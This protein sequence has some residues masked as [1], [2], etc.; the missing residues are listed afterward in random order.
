M[1]KESYP[2][3]PR[4]PKI[5]QGLLFVLTPIWFIEACRRRYG[6]IFTL[7]M[8]QYGRVHYLSDVEL[9]GEVFAADATIMHAGEA[10]QILEPVAGPH[11]V[12]LLDEDEHLRHRRMLLP[13]LH[14]KALEGYAS[15]ISDIAARHIDAWPTEEPVRLRPRLQ[16][17]TLEIITSAIFG[18]GGSTHAR[19]LQVLLD[20]LFDVG[21]TKLVLLGLRQLMSRE[22]SPRRI[23]ENRAAIDSLLVA[24]IERRRDKHDD[25]GILTLLLD[26]RDEQGE[27]LSDAAICDELVTLLLAGHETT[28]TALAWTFE[29]LVRHRPALQQLEG[30]LASDAQPYLE[31]TLNEILRVRPVVM[32]V[33]RRLAQ[34]IDLGGYPLPAGDYILP[35]IALVHASGENHDQP[36]EFRPERFLGTKPPKAV[37]L[38]FGGGPRRCLGAAFAMFEMKLIVRLVLERYTLAATRPGDERPRLRGITLVPARGCEVILRRRECSGGI[39]AEQAGA[40]AAV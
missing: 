11:S 24:E 6:G 25:S 14:G 3:G 17:I 35:S 36:A 15:L 29:R 9:I 33:G 5:V 2:P 16:T 19:E 38:P 10:N 34:P 12:L 4:L 26:A 28:A 32:D 18:E 37:W 22:E 23:R 1:A 30:E 21:A 40:V 27:P 7:R 8:P 31:A 20:E 39:A 13:P